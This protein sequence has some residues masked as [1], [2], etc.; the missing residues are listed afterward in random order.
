[1]ASMVAAAFTAVAV[2]FTV[3]AGGFTAAVVTEAAGTAK[4]A[5]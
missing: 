1:V 5:W 3:A 2:A 4:D